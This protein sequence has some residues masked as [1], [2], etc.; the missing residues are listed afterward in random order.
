MFLIW[1]LL[2]QVTPIPDLGLRTPLLVLLLRRSVVVMTGSSWLDMD[3]CM[4]ME[5]RV[6][7]IWDWLLFIPW[8]YDFCEMICSDP[9]TIIFFDALLANILLDVGCSQVLCTLLLGN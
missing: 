4:A 3:G 9:K 7:K 2:D 8:F 5:M 6:R 1:I